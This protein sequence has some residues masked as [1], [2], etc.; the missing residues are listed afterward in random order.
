MHK[1]LELKTLDDYRD[2]AQSSDVS[3]GNCVNQTGF[4][5]YPLEDY[6]DSQAHSAIVDD[7]LGIDV[8][9]TE[10]GLRKKAQEFQ[11]PGTVE[12]WSAALHE[13]TLTWVGLNPAQLQTP[14]A[15]LLELIEE[16]EPQKNDHF[17]DLGAGYGRMGVLIGQL[18]PDC[19]FTGFE[20][21]GERVDVGNHSYEK[22]GFKNA[23]LFQQNIASD[24]FELPVA[25]NYFIYDFGNLPDMKKLIAKLEALADEKRKFT[26]IAR[27]RGINSLIQQTAPWLSVE[28]KKF[29]HSVFYHYS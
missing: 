5:K 18:Y 23:H 29:R 27:G 2:L 8:I 16:L 7:I 4:F 26:V 10:K 20:M 21:A 11:G 14:Y 12:S 17:I 15:E 24:T 25:D 6:Q 28:S 22:L 13:G 19:D 3:V 9:N 1:K